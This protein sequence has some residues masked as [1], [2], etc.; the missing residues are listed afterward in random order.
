[1]KIRVALVSAL[2]AVSGCT[3]LGTSPGP[4]VA[5]QPAATPPS[6]GKIATTVI[7]AMGGGLVSGSI[8]TGLSDPE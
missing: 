3:T 8:G 1:M 4:T 5:P 2:L 7:S 6:G